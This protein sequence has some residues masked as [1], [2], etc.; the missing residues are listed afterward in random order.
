MAISCDCDVSCALMLGCKVTTDL[1]Y[2]FLRSDLGQLPYLTMCIKE[3]MRLHT[4]VPFI[5]R[6]LTAETEIDGFKLQ[7][8]TMTDILIYNIHHN[9][10]VWGDDHMVRL[11]GH[12]SLSCSIT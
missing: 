3:A 7:P 2:L 8:R 4:P 1:A 9:P 6:E 5:S 11:H 12:C 10:Q